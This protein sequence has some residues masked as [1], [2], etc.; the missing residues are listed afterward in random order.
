MLARIFRRIG[1]ARLRV[2]AWFVRNFVDGPWYGVMVFAVV[3]ST[4]PHLGCAAL[5]AALPGIFGTAEVVATNL[6]EAERA[7]QEAAKAK[8]HATKCEAGRKR[9]EK[10][11]DEVLRYVREE[12]ERETADAG[13][14]QDGGP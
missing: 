9:T 12:A 4:L 14:T 10:K 1:L 7:K 6:S 11:L 3:L 5:Q 2:R 8:A 13:A